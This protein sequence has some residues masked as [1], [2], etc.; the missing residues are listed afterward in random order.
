MGKNLADFIERFILNKFLHDQKEHILMCRNDLAVELSCAPSQISYV[1]NTRFTPERG[2]IVESRRGAGGFVKIVRIV[3]KSK[4]NKASIT[5]EQIVHDLF[6]S[7][8]ISKREYNLLSFLLEIHN[9]FL[10]KEDKIELL[11]DALRRMEIVDLS[12]GI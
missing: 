3:E 8:V 1:L 9:S 10:T 7:Q 6:T 2:F 11:K 4:K 12:G 5:A